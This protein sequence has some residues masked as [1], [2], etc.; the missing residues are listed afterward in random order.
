MNIR[1]WSLNEQDMALFGT[2]NAHM[3]ITYLHQHGYLT[4]EDFDELIGR[5]IV[6]PIH[7]NPSWGKRILNRFFKES[8]PKDSYTWVIATLP[9]EPK[10]TEDKQND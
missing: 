7:N 9:D 2:Q 3:T 5:I 8:D 1:S 6:T 4:D 10:I